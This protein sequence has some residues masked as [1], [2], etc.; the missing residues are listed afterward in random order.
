M[1][2]YFSQVSSLEELRSQYKKLLKQYRPDNASG[3]TEATQ[4]I[5]VEYER[6]F[7]LLKDR[8]ETMDQS[9]DTES[10]Y[11]KNMYNWDNDVAL[12][13]ALQKVINFNGVDI[14]IV[15][16]WIW[17]SGN[18]FAY[19]KEFKEAGFKWATNKCAWYWRS[20][21]FKKKGYKTLSMDDIRNYYGSTKVY[22]D[23]QPQ[24]AE[25]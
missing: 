5:N 1:K 18:T 19:K 6:L 21:T 11:N 8:H 12:R 23:M 17:V 15:G 14:E 24:L 9:N 10:A 22:A 4:E 25:A 3:S 13:E 16:Q 20:E 7:K 2:K